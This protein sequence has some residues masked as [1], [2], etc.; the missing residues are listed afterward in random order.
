MVSSQNLK[1][2]ALIVSQVRRETPDTTTLELSVPAELK[3]SFQYRA[4]QYLA[5]HLNFAGEEV[6]RSYSM[7][8]APEVDSHLTITIKKVPGGRASGFLV[9]QVKAGDS[10]LCGKPKGHFFHEPLA[11]CHYVLLAA[12]SGVTPLWSI[13]KHVLS[14]NSQSVITLIYTSREQ[15]QIIFRSE[16]EA[17]AHRFP[18]RLRVVHILTRPQP[19]WSGWSGRLTAKSLATLLQQS[20][21]SDFPRQYYIC[22]PTEFMNMAKSSLT[23]L[24][25]NKGDIHA[26]SFGSAHQPVKQPLEGEQPDG[27]VIVGEPLKD[28]NEKPET[29][30]AFIDGEMVTVKV[31]PNQSILDVLL[32]AGH[33]PPYS[34][35]SGS[36]TACLAQV[37]VG[38][39]K[40]KEAGALSSEN[41]GNREVLTCQTVPLSRRVRIRYQG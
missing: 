39:V 20:N 30:E 28:P 36:C 11:P 10:L 34:C 17:W 29:I 32:N 14:T 22:G 26:E 31:E 35:M 9:D 6:V 1:L 24:G 40:Q 41:F 37:E 19:G 8:S 2:F 23:E 18:E 5:V 7:S 4:G 12:G 3:D 38:R 33:N 16:L 27:S 25:V 15:D 21:T 13:L